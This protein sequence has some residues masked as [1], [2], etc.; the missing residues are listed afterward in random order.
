MTATMKVYEEPSS[1]I[2]RYIDYRRC[3]IEQEMEDRIRP[4]V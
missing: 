1:I 2:R 3:Q 4:V